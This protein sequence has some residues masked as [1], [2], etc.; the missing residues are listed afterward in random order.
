MDVNQIE[1][2]PVDALEISTPVETTPVEST[3]SLVNLDDNAL[4]E[5][6][7]G[8]Q[9][10]QKPWAEARTGFM[11]HGDYTAK[12]QTLAEQRRAFEAQ[13]AEF[14]ATRQQVDALKTRLSEVMGDPS[15]IAA[16]AMAAFAKQQ[17]QTTAQPSEP[18]P[19]TSAD[20]PALQKAI[21]EM[22]RREAEATLSARERAIEEKRLE[23]DFTTYTEGLLKD[24]PLSKIPGVADTLYAEAAKMGPKSI[25]EAK[26]FIATIVT[27]YKS[28][29]DGVVKQAVTQD[30]VQKAKVENGIQPKGG[31]AP[32]PQKRTYKNAAEQESAMV[33]W[34]EANLK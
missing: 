26:Q 29:L 27:D 5:L 34:L 15:K 30:A 10:V 23:S 16:L 25:E 17:G 21:A 14:E 11:L 13:Q 7:I 28:R 22:A 18:T 3:P 6:K 9:T 32:T 12:T 2:A 20:L 19:I 24:H 31:Q 1:T 4:V 8:G 33:A